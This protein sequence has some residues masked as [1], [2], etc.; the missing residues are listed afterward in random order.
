MDKIDES[1]IA[2]TFATVKDVDI[3]AF[4]AYMERT[5]ALETGFQVT[6]TDIFVNFPFFCLICWLVFFR[7]FYVFLS[8][9][10][11]MMI[12][13]RRFINPLK[14]CGEIYLV[15]ALIRIRYCMS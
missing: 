13:K 8:T 1:L 6:L 7:L 15:L 14:Y 11:Y 10:V 9:L 12:I 3:F 5:E 2:S 4:K